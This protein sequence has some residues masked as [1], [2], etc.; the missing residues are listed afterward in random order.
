VPRQDPDPFS[1]E[2][3][4][5]ITVVIVVTG[6]QDSARGGECDGS[7]SAEDIVVSISV[8]FSIGSEIE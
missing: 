7:D 8:E 6:K 4:P 2:C 5:D 1:L 3:I